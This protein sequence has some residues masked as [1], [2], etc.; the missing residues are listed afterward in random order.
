MVPRFHHSKRHIRS[1][2]MK[3]LRKESLARNAGKP[4]R[5]YTKPHTE[6]MRSGQGLAHVWQNIN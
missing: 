6:G 5:K 2:A 4:K 3:K 1:D